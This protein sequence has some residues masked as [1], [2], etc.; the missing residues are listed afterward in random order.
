MSEIEHIRE[1]IRELNA[2]WVGGQ[3][4]TL[5]EFF[6]PDAITAIPGR[7]ERVAGRDACV[8]SYEDFARIA[9]I[10]AFDLKEPEVDVVGAIAVATCPYEMDYE[11]E[12]GRWHGHGHDLLVMQ[13]IDEKWLI[14]W[15][16]LIAGPEERVG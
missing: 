15:R 1:R 12:S 7:P 3:A 2:R 8:R 10:H 16:M 11:I 13:K 9:R 5:A 6:H 4:A 14:L